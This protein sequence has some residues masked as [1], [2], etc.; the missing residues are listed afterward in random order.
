MIDIKFNRSYAQVHHKSIKDPGP[1][2]KSD[3][4]PVPLALPT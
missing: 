3:H 2:Q 1:K 4:V